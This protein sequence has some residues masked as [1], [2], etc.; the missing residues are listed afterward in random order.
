[1]QYLDIALR[2][3]KE[4]SFDVVQDIRVA[5]LSVSSSGIVDLP[6]DYVKY[7]K[8]GTCGD[9]RVRTLGLDNDLCLPRA[10]DSC[11]APVVKSSS[12]GLDSNIED[13]YWFMSW[14]DGESLGKIYGL[15]GGQNDYGYYR[16]DKEKNQLFLS[17]DFSGGNIVLE[18][19][20]DGSSSD[21][22][23][24]VHTFAEE[25]LRSY[26]YWKSI[27]R[28]RYMNIQEK[29]LAQQDWY[30][31]K[32]LALSRFSSFTKSEALAQSRKNFKQSPK[33]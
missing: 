11:G 6:N 4:L 15:G 29:Q 17:S 31:Q 3:L 7:T 18:Y 1:M 23:Y 30:N 14:R 10:T 13:I 24:Q 28:K 5:E 27:Q 9:G 2:G 26:V 21:G 22:N 32:R 20:S 25:A 8:I 12:D 19:I 16:I 33:F